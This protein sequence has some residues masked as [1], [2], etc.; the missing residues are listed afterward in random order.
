[1]LRV[2]RCE[3]GIP[4]LELRAA[5]SEGQER[6]PGTPLLGR[7][8]GQLAH[9]PPAFSEHCSR[10]HSFRAVE[11]VASSDSEQM[12]PS[13]ASTNMPS[14]EHLRQETATLTKTGTI[15]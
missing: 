13:T 2:S 1:M 7:A 5:P 8:P 12:P 3:A 9:I 6:G 11:P 15:V 14:R 4:L 10:A